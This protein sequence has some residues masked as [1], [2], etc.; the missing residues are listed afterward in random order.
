MTQGWWGPYPSSR[1]P[2]F[3]Y[4]ILW[5][6]WDSDLTTKQIEPGLFC[7]PCSWL[8][9]FNRGFDVLCAGKFVAISGHCTSSLLGCQSPWEHCRAFSKV[10]CYT[11]PKLCT[12]KVSFQFPTGSTPGWSTHGIGIVKWGGGHLRFS[13]QR[14][15]GVERVGPGIVL[16]LHAAEIYS[17]VP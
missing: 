15:G 8:H 5:T 9:F 2:G 1:A 16:R 7:N 17:C 10:A 13:R 6:Y 14:W 11:H 3:V 12:P 4:I